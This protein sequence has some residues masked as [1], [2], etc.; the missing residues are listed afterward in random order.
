MHWPSL[1]LQKLKDGGSLVFVYGKRLEPQIHKMF[2]EKY[3]DKG[4]NWWWSFC[5][6]HGGH[7][8]GV[9]VH[10]RG[11][12]VD[13]KPMLWYVKGN[14][15]K[16]TPNDIH[17]FIESTKP[18]KDRHPWAQSQDEAEYLVKYLTISEDAVVVDPF[19]GSGAFAI[20]AIK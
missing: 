13:W 18:D 2:L 20:P 7:I 5:V 9:R 14:K 11:V 3:D 6:Y 8:H 19:L 4:L 1:A 15:K 12:W 16:L 17:D 10:D